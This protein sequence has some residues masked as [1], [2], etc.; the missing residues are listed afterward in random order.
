MSTTI[1]IGTLIIATP[2]TCGGR[3]RIAGT[4]MTVQNIAMDYKT[5]MS[6]EEI[7]QEYPHLTLAQIYTALA[8]YHA[9]KD[10]IEAD[11]LAYQVDCEAWEK[12]LSHK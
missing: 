8:Y 10:Q 6:A 7:A 5:G 9:N 3:P 1:D 12:Q 2:E 4:R 11:I